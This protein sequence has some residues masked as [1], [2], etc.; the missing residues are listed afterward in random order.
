MKTNTIVKCKPSVGG[1]G[2]VGT[3]TDAWNIVKRQNTYIYT[4]IHIL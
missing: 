3:R 1:G 4:Y 2:D